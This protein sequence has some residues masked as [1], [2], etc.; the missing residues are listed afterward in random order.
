[1]SEIGPEFIPDNIRNETAELKEG[2]EVI[3]SAGNFEVVAPKK[4]LVPPSEG[5]H[6]RIKSKEALPP[7]FSNRSNIRD[8][9]KPYLLALATARSV[10]GDPEEK[11]NHYWSQW[12]NTHL[13]PRFGGQEKL[14]VEVIGRNARGDT[15]AEPI[16]Y[17][18]Q[19][20]YEQYPVVKEEVEATKQSLPRNWEDIKK[21]AADTLLFEEK[22]EEEAVEEV[23]H[24]LAIFR[25]NSYEVRMPKKNPHVR[26]GGI[27]LW[28]HPRLK[29][30]HEGAHSDIKEGVEQ[31]IIATAISKV[32]YQGMGVPI[33][34][35]F[36]GNWGLA[37]SKQEKEG[38][39][40]KEDLSAHANMYGAPGDKEYVE[41]P[42]RPVYER[43]T[44]E[45]DVRGKAETLLK[46]TLPKY[47]EE[48]RNFSL[49]E[50]LEVAS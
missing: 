36:S 47:L 39:K 33:E 3:F 12:V 50:V 46:N 2:D 25:F 27:H 29:D 11:D 17:P 7:Y 22:K 45:E 32:I 16:D 42:K 4:P 31:F 21:E 41:L 43:P 15:W 48:F 10:F 19:E 8:T 26:L 5:S 28:I 34:I 24:E 38:R 9:L 13:L 30:K 35:H 20:D 23:P 1:M 49:R 14:Q 44:I 40:I 6:F 18:R 37:T